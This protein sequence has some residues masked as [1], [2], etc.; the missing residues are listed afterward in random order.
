MRQAIVPQP[1]IRIAPVASDEDV[2][3]DSRLARD[4]FAYL[5]EMFPESQEAIDTYLVVQDFEGQLA[6]F[7]EHF[8]PPHGECMLARMDGAPVGVVM[9]KPYAPGVCE[10]NRMYVAREARGHGVGRGLCEGLIARARELGYREIRLDALNERVE[11]VP[12]YRKLGFL[13]DPDPPDYA[14]NEPGVVSFRMPL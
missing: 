13:P 4:F 6:A 7:R 11:A 1:L 9:L 3:D 10:L 2:A 5:R 14:R 12:L 8:S